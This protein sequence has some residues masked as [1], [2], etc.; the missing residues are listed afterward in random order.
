MTQLSRGME[1]QMGEGAVM[2]WGVEDS[3]QW[4]EMSWSKEH[5]VLQPLSFWGPAWICYLGILRVSLRQKLQNGLSINLL[6]QNN[7][8]H[9]RYKKQECHE[10]YISSFG[11][12]N[13]KTNL[14][15]SQVVIR[16]DQISCSV[17]SDSLWH[18]ESQHARPPCPS[19]TPGVHPDS[20]PSTQWCHSAISSPVVPFSSC[21]QFVPASESFPMNQLFTWGGQST[22]VSALAS[23]LPKKSQ[24]WSPSEWTG[25]ISLQSKGLSRVFSNTTV[26]KHQF[27][28]AQPSSQ[29]NSHIHTWPQE[30]P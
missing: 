15:V 3:F 7:F 17:M 29:S 18:H 9:N 22:G 28:G 27:F 13:Y 14:L 11:I 12:N 10:P 2:V 24:G 25:L 30:K 19:S 21:L 26:Q 23:F 1:I 20:C 16:S 4:Q 5:V 6:L 8:K